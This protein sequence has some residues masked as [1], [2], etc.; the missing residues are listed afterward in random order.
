MTSFKRMSIHQQKDA[1]FRCI[2]DCEQKGRFLVKSSTDN[3]ESSNENNKNKRKTKNRPINA[4]NSKH[5]SRKKANYNQ[6]A[7]SLMGTDPTNSQDK[8]LS[9]Q[10]SMTKP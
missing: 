7:S 4:D 10:K 2:D 9:M 8:N 5:Q 1:S 3:R 6:M